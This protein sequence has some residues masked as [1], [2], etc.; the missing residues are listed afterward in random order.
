[1][2]F[3][4]PNFHCYRLRLMQ[5]CSSSNPPQCPSERVGGSGQITA[6]PNAALLRE[7]WLFSVAPSNPGLGW[8][9]LESALTP[10][11]VELALVKHE[12]VPRDYWSNL[13]PTDL[14]VRA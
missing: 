3:S 12:N 10:C 5:R 1:M 11:G 14:R 7:T 6:T 2:E 8:T 9:E 13:R 4:V